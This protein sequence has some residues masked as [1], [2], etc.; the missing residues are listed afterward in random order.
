MSDDL[1]HYLKDRVETIDAKVDQL[2]AFKWQIIGGSMIASLLLTICIQIV[3]LIIRG[4][5]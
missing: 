4:V 1:L 3:A 5:T 2:L